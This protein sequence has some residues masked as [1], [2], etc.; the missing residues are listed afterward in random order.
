ML[1]EKM[2]YLFKEKLNIASNKITI[3]SNNLKVD[4]KNIFDKKQIYFTNL[5][6]KI[7]TL[8]PINTI[9]RGYS[10]TRLDN[11]IVDIKKIKK[12]DLIKTELQTGFITSKVV[13]VEEK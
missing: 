8:N 9:K 5:L 12:D 11:K 10:I 13:E 2:I 1:I 6:S 3:T 4:I 7:E